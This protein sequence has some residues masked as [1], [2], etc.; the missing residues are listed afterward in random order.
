[1]PRTTRRRRSRCRRPSGR[2][3]PPTFAPVQARSL[4][5]AAGY[6]NGVALDVYTDD[7]LAGSQVSTLLQLI[8]L[9]M[10]QIGVIIHTVY[11]DDPDQLLALE[12]HGQAPSTI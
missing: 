3:H 5:R 9:D 1:M 10:L 4:M 7:T 12:R 6:P 11:V 2:P 8:Y